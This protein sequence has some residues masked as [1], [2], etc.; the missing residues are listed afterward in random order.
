LKEGGLRLKDYSF[1]LKDYSFRPRPS[2]FIFPNR[3]FT[4]AFVL[5][6][7]CAG[8][9]SAQGGVWRKQ[10][11]GTL[12]WLHALH[13]LDAQ[14]GWAVGGNGALLA[15]VDGGATWR[16]KPRPTEDALRDVYFADADNGWLVC[17]RA[18]YQLTTKDDPRTYLMSTTDGGASWKRVNVIGV[19]VDARLVRALF[20][21]GGRGWAFGEA[22]TLYTTRDKGETWARQRVPTRHLLL[23]GA[24]LD[25]ERVWLVGAGATILQTADGGLTW[26]A[27]AVMDEAARVRFT[28]VSFVDARRGWAVGAQGRIFATRDG[29]RTWRAQT[30]NVEADLLDVKFI[31]AS[32]GWACGTEGTLLHTED[33]GAHWNVESSGTTHPL[34][35]LC[36]VTRARG[37]VVGFGGTIIAYNSNT[38]ARVPEFKSRK[39]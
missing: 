3:S 36:F 21:P 11:S 33:G 19:D 15:T 1:R 27:G 25:S 38:P 12:A 9:A 22:G 20:A 35:R 34:E 24:F 8:R 26:R 39:S 32:E 30:S 28:A 14:R 18:V 17:E 29:G 10:H 31:D 2:A 4:L 6:L 37:W 7:A 13:F 5:L 23:G 16:I